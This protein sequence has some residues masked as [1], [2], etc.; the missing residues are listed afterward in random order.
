MTGLKQ[1]V[2]DLAATFEITRGQ[3]H[4]VKILSQSVNFGTL[5]DMDG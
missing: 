2:D 4:F 3:L 1:L 5:V